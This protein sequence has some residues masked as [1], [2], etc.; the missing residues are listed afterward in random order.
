M[1]TARPEITS[2]SPRV[3]PQDAPGKRA[4]VSSSPDGQSLVVLLGRRQHIAY[5][6][7]G[8]DQ[9]AR[10]PELQAEAMDDLADRLPV[11][12]T[13]RVV[14]DLPDTLVGHQPTPV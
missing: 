5:P 7:H 9:L 3:H 10:R 13:G 2:R 4:G 8:V 1:A 6:R 14:E 12:R 11:G